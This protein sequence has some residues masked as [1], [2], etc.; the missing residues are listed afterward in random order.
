[1]TRVVHFIVIFPGALTLIAGCVCIIVLV[2]FRGKIRLCFFGCFPCC[3][4]TSRRV[5]PQEPVILQ[6][7]HAEGSGAAAIAPVIQP[8]GIPHQPVE[9]RAAPPTDLQQFHL[10]GTVPHSPS[11][12]EKQLS[13]IAPPTQAPPE[14]E[15]PHEGALASSHEPPHVPSL[16]DAVSYDVKPAAEPPR[17]KHRS[18]SLAGPGQRLV[19]FIRQK[20][21]SAYARLSHVCC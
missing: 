9:G 14:L 10:P 13:A 4:R 18:V 3:Q 11:P 21:D 1:M 7:W 12:E 16:A 5:I 19:S 20:R 6:A 2:G 15:Q 17:R 8:G